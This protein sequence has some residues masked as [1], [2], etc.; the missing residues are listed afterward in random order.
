MK[1]TQEEIHSPLWVKLKEHIQERI[2]KHRQDN[3]KM[4]PTDDTIK[5]RG[6]IAELKDLLSLE[7][8]R[9]QIPKD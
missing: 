6:R 7:K 5:L 1:L 9:P 2:D 4:L 3:D 8:E